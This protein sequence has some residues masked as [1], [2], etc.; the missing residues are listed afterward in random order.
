MH[1]GEDKSINAYLQLFLLSSLM[2]I[3]HKI[4]ELASEY[5]TV[6]VA[7]GPQNHMQII[8]AALGVELLWPR[9]IAGRPQLTL[10]THSFQ[11]YTKA[12]LPVDSANVSQHK[13]SSLHEWQNTMHATQHQH[14]HRKGRIPSLWCCMKY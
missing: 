12:S 2:Q 8:L 1:Y 7:V 3:C 6:S 5:E 4:S 10:C 9:S 13:G 11:L 14:K